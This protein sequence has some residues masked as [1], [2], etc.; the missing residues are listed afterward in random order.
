MVSIVIW[1]WNAELKRVLHSER[2]FYLKLV[3]QIALQFNDL[4]RNRI[5]HEYYIKS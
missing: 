5:T 2:K 1:I 3:D 4:L